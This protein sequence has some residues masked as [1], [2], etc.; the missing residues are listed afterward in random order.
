MQVAFVH[1]YL[2]QDG[3]AERVLL[4]LHELYPH[5]PIFTLFYV[6]EACHPA[7]QTLDVRPSPLNRWTFI[8]NSYQWLLPFMPAAVE[9]FDL[10]TYD[11]VIS[12]AYHFSKGAL[13][14]PHARHVCYC[15]TPTRFLWQDRLR[16][17][18]DIPYARF[19][20][21]PLHL[22]L[23]RL[24]QWDHQAAQR[25][26]VLIT[27]SR[28]SQQRIQRYYQR[29]STI[30][31]PPVEIDSIPFTRTPGAYWLTGGRLVGYKRFDLV[32]KAFAKL[33]LPLIVF[34]E[35]PEQKK[36]AQLAGPKTRLIGHV[37]ED[38]KRELYQHAIGF[39][40]AQE[41]DFGLTAVEAMAAGKPVLAYTHG[42][43]TE[44]VI[45]N[46]TGQFFERQCW[47]DIAYAIVHF[48][49]TKFSAEKI[50]AHA[51]QFSK[52]RFQSAMRPLLEPIAPSLPPHHA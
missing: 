7:F 27:N 44:T 5:A 41:E 19:L 39:V 38:T 33:N 4:A 12:N 24:R 2:V 45:P 14:N 11:L 17:M 31:S 1:D 18:D 35:G 47:E 6:P 32:V 49:P 26:D 50:R 22:V 37:D 51:E 8:Q 46:V 30:I 40:Y 3:G 16:Y 43:A 42:G 28:T 10:S 36:L 23:H 15:H 25:P 13:V 48:D 29:S 34:G 52:T 21:G 20:K 9:A